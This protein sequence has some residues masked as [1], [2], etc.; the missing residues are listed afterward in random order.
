MLALAADVQR[1]TATMKELELLEGILARQEEESNSQVTGRSIEIKSSIKKLMTSP[2]LIQCLNRLEV[3]GEPVWGLS[4]S[5]RDLI[6][7]A[8]EKVNNC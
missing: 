8:R 5:E 7:L 6:T 1:I 3:Q 2:D 4:S